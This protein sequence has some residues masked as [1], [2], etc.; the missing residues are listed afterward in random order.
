[1]GTLRGVSGLADVVLGREFVANVQPMFV[2]AGVPAPP[3][4]VS[5]GE[6]CV[7]VCLWV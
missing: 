3:L 4:H 2:C 1:M 5:S 6:A 7:L